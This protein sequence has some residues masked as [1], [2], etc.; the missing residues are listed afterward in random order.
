MMTLVETCKLVIWIS[1]KQA[2]LYF[3]ELI[4]LLFRARNSKNRTLYFSAAKDSS[5]NTIAALS[6]TVG[7][8]FYK[9]VSF[10]GILWEISD[11]C[12]EV[13]LH[14][15]RKGDAVQSCQSGKK[16]PQ[17]KK[18]AEHFVPWVKGGG[19]TSEQKSPCILQK[20]TPR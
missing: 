17:K 8:P 16:C 13:L 2:F 1:S 14:L 3:S 7:R 11:H 10:K 12:S 9:L 20:S 5:V 19:G 4:Q 15:G 6:L 18:L